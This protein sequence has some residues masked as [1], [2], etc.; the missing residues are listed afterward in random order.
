[1]V[2]KRLEIGQRVACRDIEWNRDVTISSANMAKKLP[3]FCRQICS[4]SKAM[5][6]PTS[7]SA[8]IRSWD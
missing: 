3:Q 4:P 5:A 1:M 8:A 6:R 2:G 7:V